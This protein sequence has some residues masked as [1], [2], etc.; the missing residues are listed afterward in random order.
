MNAPYCPP[1]HN[2]GHELLHLIARIT[3][4]VGMI[5]IP[6]RFINRKLSGPLT[7]SLARLLFEILPAA[8]RVMMQCPVLMRVRHP[9]HIGG[10]LLLL[11]VADHGLVVELDAVDIG[12]T[13][14]E[15]RADEGLGVLG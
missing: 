3:C 13:E 8:R 4:H 2:S 14:D 15:F 12:D 11:V 1:K 5:P 6:V 7:P 10:L 9:G